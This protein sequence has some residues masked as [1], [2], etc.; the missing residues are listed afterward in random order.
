MARRKSTIPERSKIE[1]AGTHAFARRTKG[2]DDKPADGDDEGDDKV[3]D[4]PSESRELPVAEGGAAADAA[5]AEPTADA[6]PED[7]AGASSDPSAP[8]PA[9]AEPAAA[10]PATA[11]PAAAEP[12]A[13][14]PSAAEPTRV[15][16]ETVMMPKDAALGAPPDLPGGVEDPTNMPGPRNIPAGDPNDPAAAPGFVPKGDSRSLRRGT[17]FALVYRMQTFLI[18]RFGVIGTRGQWRVVEY[19]T[20]GAAGNSY[21]RETSRY[22]SEGYSDYRG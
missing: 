7:D 20:P 14:E 12:T 9:A 4:A 2:A 18:S 16:S 8:A 13:A 15:R 5:Q 11:E 6:K 1:R 17:E 22:T 21:A 10:E 19:P 3:K